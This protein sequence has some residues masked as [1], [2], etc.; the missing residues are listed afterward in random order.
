[1]TSNSN[2]EEG[3]EELVDYLEKL[4]EFHLERPSLNP[5]SS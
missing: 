1:M 4:E 5:E 2:S 3:T